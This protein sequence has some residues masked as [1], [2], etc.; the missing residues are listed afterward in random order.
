MP[1]AMIVEEDLVEDKLYVREVLHEVSGGN[2]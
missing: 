1:H 2:I